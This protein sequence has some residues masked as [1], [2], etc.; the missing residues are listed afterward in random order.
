MKDVTVLNPDIKKKLKLS[1]YS[2]S[3][4]EKLT[5]IKAHTLRVWE[6]R[7]GVCNPC[8]DTNNVRRYEEE[9]LQYLIKV[10]HLTNHGHKISSIA[11]LSNQDLNELY[12]Q[13]MKFGGNGC[14]IMDKLTLAVENTRESK[15]YLMLRERLDSLGMLDFTTKIWEPMQERL[16]F[17]IL[18]GALHNV[19]LHFFDQIVER[20]IEAH[21][22]EL[23][24]SNDRCMGSALLIN[25]CGSSS[26][27]FHQLVKHTLI[28]NHFDTISLTLCQS[29][30][31]SL[32]GILNK[33]KFHH[34]L[35]HYH[36][37]K[38][39][40]DP[41]PYNEV[42]KW[43]PEDSQIYIYGA[44]RIEGDLPDRWKSMELGALIKYIDN[45][46]LYNKS[47][48]LIYE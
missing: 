36:P 29:N 47:K 8:R 41:P 3:E 30:W 16:G 27:M 37:S 22:I 40:S 1:Q 17:L 39:I 34:V 12:E 4:L 48:E 6:K 43:L 33:R 28:T 20:L 13:S 9:D 21:H 32:E 14:C 15:L 23:M 11:S 7:Y 2:I 42:E 18:S 26:T 31:S 19:H 35:I 10:S 38:D 5:G 45:G 44:K 46:R 25:S 24:L